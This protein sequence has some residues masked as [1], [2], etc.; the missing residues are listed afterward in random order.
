[1]SLV[2]D[3][4][5]DR[6]VRSGSQLEELVEAVCRAEDAISAMVPGTSTP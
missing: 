1:M 4:R 2:E 6:L 5:H 3:W